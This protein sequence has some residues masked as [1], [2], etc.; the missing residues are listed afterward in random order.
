[1]VYVI[2]DFFLPGVRASADLLFPKPR[3]ADAELFQ[4]DI[5]FVLPIFVMLVWI[6]LIVT[7]YVFMM[8]SVKRRELT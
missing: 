4:T 8:R 7:L 3:C 2:P 1:M 6:V 5:P